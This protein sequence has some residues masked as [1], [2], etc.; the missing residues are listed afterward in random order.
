MRN[1][2]VP[3]FFLS[4]AAA[5]QN[6]DKNEKA[7]TVREQ[8]EAFAIADGYKINLYASE[9]DSP[10]H[11]PTGMAFDSRGRLWVSTAP[12][13]LQHNPGVRPDD[14]LIIYND[15]DRDGVADKHTVFADKLY[16]PTGFAIDTGGAWVAQKSDLLFLR[17]TDGD[18]VVD[19]K[20]IVLQGFG[21][22]SNHHA[23]ST[24]TWGPEG[25]LYFC[26]GPFHHTQVETP[27]GP[28][29]LV[30]AGVHRFD[31]RTR[32]LTVISHC[33]YD[34][35]WDMAF[36]RWGHSVLS[37]ASGGQHYNFGAVIAAFDY[38]DKTARPEPFLHRGHPVTGNIILSSRHFPE[39]V[40]GTFLNNQNTSFQRVRWNR[41]IQEGSGWT[42]VPLPDLLSS[43]NS[44]FHPVASATGPDGAL[45][46]LDHCNPRPDHMQHARSGGT[47]DHNHGRIWR[48]TAEG[49]LLL[50]Q[51]KIGGE[52][53][54]VLL[55]LLKTHEN[56]VRHFTRR[57][58]CTRETSE[59]LR[60]LKKWIATLDK[61]HPEYARHLLEALWISAGTDSV[62]MGLLQTLLKAEDA[63]AR[64][65]ATRQLR[66]WLQ[67][68]YISSAEALRLLEALTTDKNERVRMEAVST[69]G[70]IPSAEAATLALRAKQLPMDQNTQA[71][72]TQTLKV[73]KNTRL[74]NSH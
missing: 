13:H 36:D 34:N 71:V 5:D 39:D 25:A 57:E 1:L 64:A 52:P 54:P 31:P 10:L 73:L 48:I 24:F 17:D 67:A 22:G 20:E 60:A 23:L 47:Q 30:D 65:G 59:I 19:R 12:S 18:D 42:T 14:K 50:T 46:I 43:N 4:T 55:D 68:G 53:I 41:L 8:L 63:R 69:C 33:S 61:E 32:R 40:Q 29:R 26:E 49:R 66:H 11:N 6:T 38:P 44:S 56:H 62:Q 7:S 72:L 27:W 35:P 28:Q 15:T 16:D 45:Y 70:F 2:L 51:P 3:V 9:Q 37:D 58:L 21:T 74:L